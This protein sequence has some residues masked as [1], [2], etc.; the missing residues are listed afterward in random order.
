M[1]LAVC[2]IQISLGWEEGGG[3]F[4]RAQKSVTITK[5]IKTNNRYSVFVC[6]IV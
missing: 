3:R 5:M 4:E 1:W 6:Y 2:T